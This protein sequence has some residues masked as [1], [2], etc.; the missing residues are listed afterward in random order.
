MTVLLHTKDINN[1]TEVA[2][3]AVL[4][5]TEDQIAPFR[6]PICSEC[7]LTFLLGYRHVIPQRLVAFNSCATTELVL[8]NVMKVS[9][10]LLRISS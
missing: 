1:V 2:K 3:T 10:L 8:V 9:A 7:P 6:K 5:H 4:P